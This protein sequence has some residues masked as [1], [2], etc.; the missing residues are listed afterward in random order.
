LQQPHPSSTPNS[1]LTRSVEWDLLG[2]IYRKPKVS[3]SHL[4]ICS[5]KY[6]FWFDVTVNDVQFVQ[7]FQNSQKWNN[8][9][10]AGLSFRDAAAFF[11]HLLEQIT[12]FAVLQDK[13]HL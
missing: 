7:R 11:H 2:A 5:Q 12:A 9:I 1:E 8:H 3:E 4:A 10:R 6:V 13:A